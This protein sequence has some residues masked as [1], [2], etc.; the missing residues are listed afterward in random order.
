MG[1]QQR[2]DAVGYWQSCEHGADAA[3]FTVLYTGSSLP[4]FLDRTEAPGRA[5]PA[6][7]AGLPVTHTCVVDSLNEVELKDAKKRVLAA[8]VVLNVDA[9]KVDGKEL[10]SALGRKDWSPWGQG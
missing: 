9:P 1:S 8:R 2:Q 5:A 10:W 3:R 6:G 7:L 4:T